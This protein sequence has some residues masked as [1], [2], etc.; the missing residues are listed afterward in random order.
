MYGF[1]YVTTNHINNKKYI[2][3]KKYDK[4]GNWKKYIGSGVVL[5]QAIKK[6]GIE[7]FSKEI[8]EECETKE[9]LNAR[10]K[11][12]I[13]YYDAVKS[14]GYYNIAAGGDGGN[15]FAGYTEEQLIK[16]SQ[17]LSQKLKGNIN[18]GKNNPNAKQVICLNNMKIF[19]TTID[20]AKYG[21]TTDSLIQQCCVNSKL[22]TAGTHPITKERLQWEYYDKNKNYIFIPY[23]RE[24]CH[25]KVLCLNTNIIYNSANEASKET[26]CS[27]NGIRHCCGGFYETTNG[28][29]FSYI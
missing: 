20:A 13:S 11:Y 16:H 4:R 29:K 21:N 28:M 10:E 17:L 5:K 3:Q 22:H 18:Q 25:K 1:I 24:Y 9:E 14:Y 27:I 6:Y 15:V 23:K 8:I 12:W 26:G 7:N 19:D 2:G